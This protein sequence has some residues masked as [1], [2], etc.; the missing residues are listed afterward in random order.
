MSFSSNLKY[1]FISFNCLVSSFLIGCTDNFETLNTDKY[2]VNPNELPFTAQ[3]SKPFTYVYPP[4]QNLFQFWTNLSVDLF[5]GYFMTPH[6]FN[7]AGNVGY[8]LNRLFCSG[9]YENTYLQL[10]NNTRMLIKSCDDKGYSDLAGM[11]RIVQ[12]YT[13]QMLTDSYGPMPYRSV[14]ENEGMNSNSFYY[15]SQESIYNDLFDLIDKAIVGFKESTYDVDAM[16][17]F[18]YWCHGDMALWIKVANQFKLRLAMRIV[19]VNPTLAR[20]KAEEAVKGGVL[21]AEDN[22]IIVNQGLSNELTRM[23]EWGDCGINASLV[24]IMQGYN[25][26]RLPLYITKN[27]ADI[28]A[29]NGSV[30]PAGT[31]YHGIRGGCVLGSKPNQWGNFSSVVCDYATPFPVMKVSE[32]YFLRAEGALRGWNMNGSAKELYEEGIRSSIKHE[33]VYKSNYVEGPVAISDEDIENYINGVTI[34]QDYIDPVDPQNNYESL[35]KVCVKWDENATNEE[36]LQRIITQ[37]WIALFPLSIEAWAEYRRTGYPKLFPNRINESPDKVD[38][39]EQV[40]RLIYPEIELNTN[41]NEFVNGIG[42]LNK[43]NSSTKFSGDIGGTRVW[44]DRADKGNF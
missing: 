1:M 30:I 41:Y 15:D 10:F 3:F 13:I 14:I 23:F 25:D 43:E 7:G 35:N 28:T 6:N 26:P 37:K 27:Q 29:A 33:I 36:K 9:I 12:V 4:H 39:D 32:A 22:D 42:I 5:S 31:E 20:A 24:T 2:E 44:W 17:E 34:Q 40:R 19:K 38:T 8:N 16:K 21:T 18:D 11:M